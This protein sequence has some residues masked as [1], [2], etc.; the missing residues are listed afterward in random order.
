MNGTLDAQ[1]KEP[2]FLQNGLFEY[3]YAIIR[4]NIFQYFYIHNSE[5]EKDELNGLVG[6]DRRWRGGRCG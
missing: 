4:M 5:K 6:P 1:G 3:A 2:S